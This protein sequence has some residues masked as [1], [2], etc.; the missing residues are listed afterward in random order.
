MSAP[1]ALFSTQ[2]DASSSRLS[3]CCKQREY[4]MQPSLARALMPLSMRMPATKAS[5]IR[6]SLSRPYPTT[7]A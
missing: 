3:P 7:M 5:T 6:R 1:S 2:E 4:M